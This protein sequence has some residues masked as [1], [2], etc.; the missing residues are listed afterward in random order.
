MAVPAAPPTGELSREVALSTS[1]WHAP[2]WGPRALGLLPRNPDHV[3]L[4]TRKLIRLGRLRRWGHTPASLG[5]ARFASMFLN[6]HRREHALLE[7]GP[8]RR[9]WGG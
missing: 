9:L 4:V 1:T 5:E 3:L 8:A 2:A 6:H 7:Q